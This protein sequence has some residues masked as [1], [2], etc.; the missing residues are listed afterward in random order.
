MDYVEKYALSIVTPKAIISA[1]TSS[2]AP[3]SLLAV[4]TVNRT[5]VC[6]WSGRATIVL[7]KSLVYF[8]STCSTEAVGTAIT[9]P[10]SLQCENNRRQTHRH[11]HTNQITVPSL[12]MRDDN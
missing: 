3:S 8:S 2:R 1:A 7:A 10:G 4:Y 11:T 6:D 9:P 12:S 5:F